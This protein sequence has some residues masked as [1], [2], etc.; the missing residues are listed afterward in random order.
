[1]EDAVDGAVQQATVVADQDQRAG[2][3]LEIALQPD[4]G[5]Q[6]QVVGRLVEQQQVRLREQQRGQ[7]HAHPPAAGEFAAGAL[8][9]RLVE[10]E[11]GE[12]PRRARRGRL[13]PD[14]GQALVNLGQPGRI[15]GGFG[16]GQQGAAF[17]VRGQHRVEQRPAAAGRL[18]GHLADPHPARQPHVAGVGVQVTGDQPQQCRL[19]GAVAPDQ[20]HT[21]A[22]LDRDRRALE[23]GSPRVAKGHVVDVQHAGR[24]DS[25]AEARQ[26][27][28]R[29]VRPCPSRRAE[30]PLSPAFPHR[31]FTHR[32][33]A[34]GGI[35]RESRPKAL[36]L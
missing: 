6:V 8:L 27:S 21:P 15:A 1:M 4:R 34:L 36:L 11:A 13:G 19:A 30:R 33:R 9:C 7:R 3:G 20:A 24:G 17:A 35:A 18:L 22:A 32:R 12:D 14:H 26:L 28:A 10:A 23:D 16:L 5:L 31:G 29:R 2:I 25:T